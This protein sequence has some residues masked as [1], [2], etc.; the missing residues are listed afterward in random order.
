M[1]KLGGEKK[2]KNLF[3]KEKTHLPKAAHYCSV[4]NPVSQVCYLQPEQSLHT[5]ASISGGNLCVF[6]LYSWSSRSVLYTSAKDYR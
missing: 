5:R 4:S 1:L 2:K 3:L 6:L